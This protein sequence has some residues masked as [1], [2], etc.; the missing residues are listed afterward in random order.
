[1]PLSCV[2]DVL[3][4][5]GKVALEIYDRLNA[6][7][8]GEEFRQRLERKIK[9]LQNV[10]DELKV[11]GLK[12]F[13][14]SC[15]D[16]LSKFE[17]SLGQ[18]KNICD[19]ITSKS[20]LGKFVQVYKH[21][22]LLQNLEKELENARNSLQFA[23]TR[24]LFSQNQELQRRVDEGTA[25]VEATVV[26]PSVGVYHGTDTSAKL[27][28]PFRIEKPSVS[29]EGDLM[30]VKWV[31]KQ[32]SVLEVDRFEVRYDDEKEVVLPGKPDK[33]RCVDGGCAFSM[34]LGHPR[35]RLGQVYTIQVRAVNKQGPGE[36][37]KETVVRYKVGPPNKPR[38]PSLTVMS[39]TNVQVE[40]PRLKEEEEN[41]SKVSECIVEYVSVDD[42]NAS[43]W[44]TLRCA[45]KPSSSDNK[46]IKFSI[47]G[48]T[49]SSTYR[50]RVKMINEAG[51]S[52]PSDAHEVVTTQLIPGPPKDLRV[53]SKRT[54]KSI[55]IRW[56]PPT[57]NPHAVY[58]Y[59]VDIQQV[60]KSVIPWKKIST[61]E[62]EK[63]SATARELSTDTKYNFRVRAVNNKGEAG[64]YTN[65]IQAETRYGKVGCIA[66]ATGAFFGG[67]VGGPLIG[68]AGIGGMAGLAARESADSKPGKVVGS[69]AAGVGGGIG[70]AII[71]TVGAPVMGATAA[72]LA[73]NAMT[74]DLADMSPQ[75]SEDEDQDSGKMW[76]QIWKLSKKH[77]EGMFK[78]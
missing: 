48:L 36:W 53:S 29:L 9:E 47:K 18:C 70:G 68:A 58:R 46:V 54:D 77:S 41:G 59:E 38:K 60:Q 8:E 40:V 6:L 32:N 35:I 39:P 55:K 23:L 17:D 22:H 78:K 45:V 64:E 21:E 15:R 73:Y 43:E 57:E 27:A 13:P 11:S 72:V 52:P 63:L 7:S 30:V 12:E 16:C 14:T 28:K 4:L 37:S 26:H 19:A 76:S 51:E 24:A 3:K 67:T 42:T 33:L 20:T 62:H 25:R 1:M 49:P 66:A 5:S 44:Q 74:G 50:F 75:S 34:S 2:G 56:G 31:D 61:V 69:I 71:G 65:S 10:G